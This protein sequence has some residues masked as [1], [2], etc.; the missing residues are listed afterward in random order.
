L[1]DASQEI[2]ELNENLLVKLSEAEKSMEKKVSLLKEEKELFTKKLE[3]F[4][5]KCDSNI[6]ILQNSSTENPS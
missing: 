2:K 1:K 3:K 6:S 4:V 5:E